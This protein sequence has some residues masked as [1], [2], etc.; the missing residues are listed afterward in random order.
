MSKEK[1]IGPRT[2]K[3]YDLKNGDKI[4]VEAEGIGCTNEYASPDAF[5]KGKLKYKRIFVRLKTP[6]E[7]LTCKPIT[8]GKDFAQRVAIIESWFD[9]VVRKG[10]Y[11]LS[12]E[13]MQITDDMADEI[14]VQNDFTPK[15]DKR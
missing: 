9:S 13:A 6:E 11:V 15:T 2:G 8:D 1:Y 10:N 4:D 3:V 5:V 12:F 7:T 14:E